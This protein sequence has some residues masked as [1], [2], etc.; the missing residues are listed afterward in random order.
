[1][2]VPASPEIRLEKASGRATCRKCQKII[3]KG[4]WEII[5]NGGTGN[6]AGHFHF[7]CFYNVNEESLPKIVALAY[8]DYVPEEHDLPD[9]KSGFDLL[10]EYWDS[11]PDEEKPEIHEKMIEFGL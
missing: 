3:P 9:Y 1:M 8:G 11:L 6:Y 5:M 7:N 10:M 2:V 4:E